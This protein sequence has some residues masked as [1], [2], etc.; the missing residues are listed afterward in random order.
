[1]AGLTVTVSIKD[2][3]VFKDI[4]AL[5]SELS[6]H[7]ESIAQRVDEIMEKHASND[8]SKTQCECCGELFQPKRKNNKYCH[9]CS[10]QKAYKR[11]QSK[12]EALP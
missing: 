7:D 10:P 5:L 12:V 3:E 9:K 6:E 2:T 11:R 4:M 1:M 8:T